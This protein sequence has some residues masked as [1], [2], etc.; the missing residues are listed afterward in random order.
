MK[1]KSLKI[2]SLLIISS[3]IILSAQ[4]KLSGLKVITASKT[5]EISQYGITWTFSEPVEYGTYITGDYWVVGPVEIVTIAPAS[6]SVSGRV[7][8][9]SMVNPGGG[10]SNAGFDSYNSGYYSPVLNVAY[11]LNASNTYV[12]APGVSI[13]SSVS[14]TSSAERDEF[15]SDVAVLTVVAEEPEPSSFRP[16]YAGDDKSLKF[17]YS[18][19]D[20]ILLQS[21]ATLTPVSGMPAWWE[22]ELQLER[23]FMDFGGGWFRRQIHGDHYS[24]TYGRET[25]QHNGII[26]LML[27]TNTSLSAK[28]KTLIRFIQ[29]GIDLYGIYED[30]VGHGRGT[31]WGPNGGHH[32]GRKW[33]IMFTG[34]LLGHSGMMNVGYDSIDRNDPFHEDGQTEYID[35]DRVANTQSGFTSGMLA[36]LLENN[37][38]AWSQFQTDYPSIAA[39]AGSGTWQTDGRDGEYHP[40]D[41]SMIGM[42]EWHAR[43]EQY[44]EGNAYFFYRTYRNVSA[45]TWH[46]EALAALV[47]HMETQWNHD[48][49]F[50]YVHRHMTIARTATDP[51]E[52][53]GYSSVGGL[54]TA[55]TSWTRD[56]PNRGTSGTDIGSWAD[57]MWDT[58]WDSYYDFPY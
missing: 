49:F 47:M 45:I 26:S 32:G 11:G 57:D 41:S 22:A 31:P 58:Y 5:T 44:R 56:W 48:A 7:I 38:S 46:A 3:S 10:I 43:G 2:L 19:V 29:R 40:Y 6:V 25:S 4:T 52:V 13:V 33:A 1:S 8:N 51:F 28:Q 17:T 16:P 12:A 14:N 27:L 24:Y 15:L 23:P 9:G 21:R 53:I 20:T 39:N 37:P 18:D 34:A 35:S 42:P 54:Q 50:D 55:S 30:S 36:D